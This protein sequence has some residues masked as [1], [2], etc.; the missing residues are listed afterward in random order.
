MSALTFAGRTLVGG[1]AR[2]PLLI[3]SSEIPG[4][5]GIDPKT[6]NIV[7]TGHPQHGRSIA[8]AILIIPGAKGASGWSGQFHI[9]KVLGNA[10]AAVVTRRL[11]TKLAL[12]LAVLG[13]PALIDLPDDAYAALTDGA[14]ATV[15]DGRLTL[16]DTTNQGDKT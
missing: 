9:A 10:P 11:N 3:C 5:G 15:K 12:A 7:E 4:W 2:G 6:G 14:M 8:G 16:H 13:V 1:E